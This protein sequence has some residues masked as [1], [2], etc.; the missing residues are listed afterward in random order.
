MPKRKV[1]ILDREESPWPSFLEEF[2]NDTRASLHIA[3]KSGEAGNLL[4]EVHPDLIFLKEEFLS[5]TFL[6]KIK[7]LR[8]SS[9][10]FRVFRLATQNPVSGQLSYDGAFHEPLSFLEF[11]KELARYLPFHDPVQVLIVDDEPE[12]ARALTEYLIQSTEPRFHVQHASNGLEGLKQIQTRKPDV[13]LLDIKMPVM[14]GHELYRKLTE[15]KM[16][17]PVIVYFDGIFGDEILEIH[18]I[19]NPSV[20]EKGSQE[21][22]VPNMTALI[23]KMAYFG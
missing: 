14:T 17:V 15:D 23:Q 8:Q 18:K 16:E 22:S 21:S 4:G 19:G 5:P 2:F 7:A 10:D 13:L 11:Q 3:R 20:I 9:P 6:Q 1:L 12:I